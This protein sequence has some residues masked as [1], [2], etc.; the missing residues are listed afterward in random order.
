MNQGRHILCSTDTL[1]EE[2]K[3]VS[4]PIRA[5]ATCIC[6]IGAT[7]SKCGFLEVDAVTNQQINS[8]IPYEFMD[9]VYV[10]Y[11]CCGSD[12]KDILISNAS[13]TTLPI[14]N[15]KKTSL[16]NITYPEKSEQSEIVRIVDDLLVKEQQAKEASEA[17]LEQIDTM[18]KAILARAFRGELGTN[19]PTEESAVELL[20]QI[21]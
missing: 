3:A 5:G 18:K 11:Y 6:C 9:D 10:Y 2:G 12:F 14:I 7:I 13:A 8:V 21:I 1:T 15:K 4:R 16:L 20:K 17:V 19:D